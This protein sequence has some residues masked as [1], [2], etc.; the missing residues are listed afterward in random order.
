VDHQRSISHS[1][2]LAPEPV[3]PFDR[4]S[5]VYRKL[6]FGFGE[7]PLERVDGMSC[8]GLL[9]LRVLH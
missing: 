8:G 5:R 7:E 2:A 6:D 4:F 3:A 1:S 9:L